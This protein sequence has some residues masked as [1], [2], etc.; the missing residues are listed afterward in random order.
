MSKHETPDISAMRTGLY[1]EG[2]KI[3]RDTTHKL[4]R[5]FLDTIRATLD[6]FGLNAKQD[7]MIAFD[8]YMAKYKIYDWILMGL[9]GRY[10]D[11]NDDASTRSVKNTL[12]KFADLYLKQKHVGGFAWWLRGHDLEIEEPKRCEDCIESYESWKRGA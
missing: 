12:L 8:L 9:G 6:C 10:D 2:K 3:E 11:P 7:Q 5:P 1:M 4:E